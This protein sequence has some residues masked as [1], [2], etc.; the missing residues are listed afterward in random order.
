MAAL[1][2]FYIK[3]ND[4]R[5]PVIATCQDENGAAEDLTGAT[6]KFHMTGPVPATTSKVNSAG[7][8]VDAANGVVKYQWIAADTNTAG[9]FNA[10]FQIT[11]SDA[12]VKTYP[13]TA[14]FTVHVTPDLGA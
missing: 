8:L 11:F 5:E 4:T 6:V 9:D 7:A 12:R 2:D 3:Q 1:T 13:N 10:E 14:N